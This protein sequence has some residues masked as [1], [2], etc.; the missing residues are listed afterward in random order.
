[1]KK[2][3]SYVLATAVTMVWVAA[4]MYATYPGGVGGI[5]M[6]KKDRGVVV[7]RMDR[8]VFGSSREGARD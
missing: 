4:V 6:V 3:T 1:M 7:S 5:T 8:L 2:S